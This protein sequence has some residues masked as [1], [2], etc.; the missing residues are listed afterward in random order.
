MEKLLL[1]K[2][3]PHNSLEDPPDPMEFEPPNLLVEDMS[4]P[5]DMSQMIFKTR[6]HVYDPCH[7]YIEI[8]SLISD[9]ESVLRPGVMNTRSMI[10]R[11]ACDRYVRLK[12]D[13]QHA[14]LSIIAN[15]IGFDRNGLD[16][17]VT[18]EVK[19]GDEIRQSRLFS[20]FYPGKSLTILSISK[21]GKV[22]GCRI[23]E[24]GTYLPLSTKISGT[25]CAG[26]SIH[27]HFRP[28]MAH[29]L[30]KNRFYGFIIK[31][32]YAAYQIQL[33]AMKLLKDSLQ[34]VSDGKLV[35]TDSALA[36]RSSIEYEMSILREYKSFYLAQMRDKYD[37][38]KGSYPFQSVG[39]SAM[40][41]VEFE[42]T[43]ANVCLARRHKLFRSQILAHI[44][45]YSDEMAL[46]LLKTCIERREAFLTSGRCEWESISEVTELREHLGLLD[47]LFRENVSLVYSALEIGPIPLLIGKLYWV[48]DPSPLYLMTGQKLMSRTW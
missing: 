2:S 29:L 12:F 31:T 45:R 25:V 17:W 18:A 3:E 23:R 15:G 27:V 42:A 35:V 4:F 14:T 5:N 20:L 6:S 47:N 30:D 26:T 19:S 40:V 24:D 8:P 9:L 43:R 48:N 34:V 16:E 11:C 33:Y 7:F 1:T 37:T 13:I 46:H 10:E 38:V 22:F 28:S 44:Q 21:N 32:E 41:S 39:S 36:R